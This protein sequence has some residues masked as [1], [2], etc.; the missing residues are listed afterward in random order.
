M[1]RAPLPI[2]ISAHYVKWHMRERLAPF[3]FRG[4]DE[5]DRGSRAGGAV[6]GRQPQGYVAEDVRGGSSAEQFR[7][8]AGEL[9]GGD[10]GRTADGCVG[11]APGVGGEHAEAVA[12]AGV[13]LAGNQAAPG[14]S[15]GN[16]GGGIWGPPVV[17]ACFL[18]TGLSLNRLPRPTPTNPQVPHCLSLIGLPR[19]LDKCL[20]P[21]ITP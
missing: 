8:P 5:A 18:R 19:R 6:A 12:E 13:T 17:A 10:S 1:V 21:I 16:A 4:R 14:T 20:N 9:G 2:C 7:G 11:R 15:T 3:L